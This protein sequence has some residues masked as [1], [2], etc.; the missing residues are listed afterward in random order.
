[1]YLT[2]IFIQLLSTP[3]P[4]DPQDA[5]VAKMYLEDQPRFVSTAKF[6]TEAYAQPKPEGTTNTTTFTI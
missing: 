5:V 6:W 2:N 4:G 3:E 1:M